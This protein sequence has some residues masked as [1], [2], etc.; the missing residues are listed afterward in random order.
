LLTWLIV[1]GFRKADCLF[2]WIKGRWI[3]IFI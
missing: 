2:N 1:D 3:Y